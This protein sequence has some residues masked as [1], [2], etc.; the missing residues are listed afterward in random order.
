MQHVYDLLKTGYYDTDKISLTGM[1]EWSIKWFVTSLQDPYTEYFDTKENQ[2][3]SSELK[4][5][6]EFEWIWAAVQ[7][8]DTSIQIQEVYKDTPAARAWLRPLDLILE[9]NGEKTTNMTTTQ[10]VQK[11]RGAHDT[12]VKLTIYR[13]TAQDK[14]LFVVEVMREKVSIPTVTSDIITITWSKETIGYLSIGIIGEQTDA[15]V[16]KALDDFTAHKVS[17][18]ILDLRWNGG[19]YLPVSVD[20]ASHFLSGGL[21]VVTAK[22]RTM[23]SEQYQSM[24]TGNLMSQPLVVLVD[25][26]TASAGEIIAWALQQDRKALLV[27]DTTYGKGSIQT[28]VELTSGSAL[29]YTVWKRYLP[30]DTNIDHVGIKPDVVSLFDKDLYEKQH[31]DSQKEQAFL[32]MKKILGIK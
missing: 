16:S 10:A 4:G 29:K 21:S 30:D 14:K 12:K 32:E 28:V 31:L 18:I 5:T 22:Y 24:N 20:V 3:F 23:P 15:L 9:I 26:L 13:A 6:D 2:D 7:K 19:G 25:G 1:W 11:I 17:W 27:W 8:K